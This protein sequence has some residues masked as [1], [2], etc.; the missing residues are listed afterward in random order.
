MIIK[1]KIL[2]LPRSTE[3]YQLIANT[4][5]QLSVFIEEKILFCLDEILIVE[6]ARTLG[7]W[8]QNYK[9]NIKEDF[10]YNSMDFEEEPVLAFLRTSE[11]KFKI[12][13]ALLDNQATEL[14]SENELIKAS[15]LFLQNLHD[16]LLNIGLEISKFHSFKLP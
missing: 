16:E 11:S 15:E 4:E 12:E 8:L 10:V 1:F 2:S 13:S 3:T 5:G 7:E 14:I 6:L 9:F